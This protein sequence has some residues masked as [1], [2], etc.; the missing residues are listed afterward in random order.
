MNKPELAK[1][2]ACKAGMTKSD[3]A[4]FIDAFI[5]VVGET[6]AEGD[7]VDLKGFGSFF[8]KKREARKGMA[9][10]KEIDMPASKTVG[11]KAGKTLKDAVN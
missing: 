7:S 2:I 6:V 11:F 1:E 4:K 10:G 9:F 8:L 3:S 5:E